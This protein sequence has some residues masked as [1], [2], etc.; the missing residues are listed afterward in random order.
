VLVQT[1]PGCSLTHSIDRILDEKRGELAG[2]RVKRSRGV[3]AERDAV[4][5]WSFEFRFILENLVT[6]AVRAMRSSK[7]RV[8]SIETVT[9]GTVCFVRVSDTGV[10]MDEATAGRIFEAKDDERD[11]GFGMP[12][13]RLRLREHGGDLIIEHTAPEEGT[14]FLLTIP[15]WIPNTGESDV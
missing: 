14:T 15:H 11:G 1:N 3:P 13:S 9:D 2:I 12:N 8:F 4:A 7:E 5:L 6:N 10:G